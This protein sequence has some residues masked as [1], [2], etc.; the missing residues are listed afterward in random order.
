MSNGYSL[1]EREGKE[2]EKQWNQDKRRDE[3]EEDGLVLCTWKDR[4]DF[5]ERGASRSISS[6]KT[7][8]APNIT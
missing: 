7:T 6:L 2:E 3:K 8:P 5:L 4:R 1:R